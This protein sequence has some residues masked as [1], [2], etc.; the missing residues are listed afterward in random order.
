MTVCLF[1]DHSSKIVHFY[2]AFATIK[3]HYEIPCCKLSSLVTTST[4]LEAFCGWLHHWYVPIELPLEGISFRHA[5]LCF[6]SHLI[7]LWSVMLHWFQELTY[8]LWF[9]MVMAIMITAFCVIVREK[10]N[11]KSL[12]LSLCWAWW[13]DDDPVITDPIS[14]PDREIGLV[15]VPVCQD[16]NCWNGWPVR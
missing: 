5:I 13:S 9:V 14:G 3:H 8:S 12:L 16:I 6:W 7:L 1:R 10:K 2:M 15:C 4:A 11:H